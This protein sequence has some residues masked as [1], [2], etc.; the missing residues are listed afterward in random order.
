MVVGDEYSFAPVSL[1]QGPL[2]S[3]LLLACFEQIVHNLPFC[4]INA[5]LWLL[6]A[7]RPK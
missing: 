6:L 3:S 1:G 4:L 7:I 5:E 2:A